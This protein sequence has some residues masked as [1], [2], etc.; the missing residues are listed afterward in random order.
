MYPNIS[1]IYADIPRYTKYQA[2][3]DRRLGAGPGGTA[4]PPLG[5]LYILVHVYLC[6][7]WKYLDIYLCISIF[8]I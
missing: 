3:A 1:K 5:I 7:S 8:Y 2:A 4:P 6:V